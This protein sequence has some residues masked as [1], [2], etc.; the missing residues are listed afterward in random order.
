MY[1]EDRRKNE[2]FLWR[3]LGQER[4]RF[5]YSQNA[6]CN[7]GN[8]YTGLISKNPVFFDLGAFK[9]NWSQEMLSR[10]GGIS[11][12]FEIHPELLEK[13]NIT[14]KRDFKVP[15]HRSQKYLCDFYISSPLRAI[16]E[17]KFVSVD[18]S[19]NK[20]RKCNRYYKLLV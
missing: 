4:R 16:I 17:M 11:H 9:G 1:N 2:S 8:I 14:Y 12:M 20:N 10:F 6:D 3:F 7:Y 13:L 15:T 19:K 18:S 5:D